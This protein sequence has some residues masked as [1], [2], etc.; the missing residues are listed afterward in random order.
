MVARYRQLTGKSLD[1]PP[2][3]C[4]G[5]LIPLI[6]DEIDRR[7]AAL[8]WRQK[9]KLVAYKEDNVWRTQPYAE[10]AGDLGLIWASLLR[11]MSAVGA[12]CVFLGIVLR[13]RRHGDL[14]RVFFGLTPILVCLGVACAVAIAEGRS[15]YGLV[16]QCMLPVYGAGVLGLPICTD[17]KGSDDV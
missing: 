1:F 4:P 10:W 13:A 3:T 12:V 5:E 8:S 6:K 2:N 7:W 14:V 15:R 17:K 16:A 9:V 11:I